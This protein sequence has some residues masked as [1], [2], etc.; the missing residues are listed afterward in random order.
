MYQMSRARIW[1]IVCG[2]SK[3]ACPFTHCI[4]SAHTRLKVLSTSGQDPDQ[5]ACVS[6]RVYA[7]MKPDWPFCPP[8]WPCYSLFW[9]YTLQPQDPHH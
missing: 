6:G 9:P 8:H 3:V 7:V 2:A 1:A 4:F 5:R